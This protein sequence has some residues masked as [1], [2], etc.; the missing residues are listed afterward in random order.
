MSEAS[1]AAPTSNLP[2]AAETVAWLRYCTIE[3]TPSK[4]TQVY[5]KMCAKSAPK[6]SFPWLFGLLWYGRGKQCPRAST[7]L[8][9]VL[10]Y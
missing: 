4:P 7:L 1:V 2:T 9:L 10:L 6:V 8:Y 5:R 3:S